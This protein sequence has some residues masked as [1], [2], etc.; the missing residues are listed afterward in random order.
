MSKHPLNRLENTFLILGVVTWL[1]FFISLSFYP[2]DYHEQIDPV[3]IV[4]YSPFSKKHALSLIVFLLLGYFSMY[5][6]SIHGRKSP[7]LQTVVY[8]TLIIVSIVLV[9][10][11]M[12]QVSYNEDLWD[13][14]DYSIGWTMLLAL[15]LYFLLAMVILNKFVEQE[16]EVSKAR[17]YKNKVLNFLNSKLTQS[18]G[19]SI[20]IFIVALPPLLLVVLILILFGQD[21]DSLVK[22]FTETTTW[23][24]SQKTHPPFL[25][26]R[27]HYLCTVA[28]CGSPNIVKPQRIGTRHGTA[29]IVNRQLMVANAFEELIQDKSPK[30]HRWLRR[31]YDKYGYPLSKKIKTKRWSN[32]TYIL[33]KPLEWFFLIVLYAFSAQPEQKIK[34]QYL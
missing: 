13:A 34:R 27:G 16:R 24:F 1:V 20:W 11:M 30:V 22:V 2:Y 17:T 14:N 33:M 6:I 7:P 29:I 12:I 9:I 32:M 4:G 31:N 21:A 5:R 10:L 8:L 26:H 18:E 23:T 3:T 19:V 28:A 15:I 25:D